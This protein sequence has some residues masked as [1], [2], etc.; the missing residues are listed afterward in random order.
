MIIQVHASTLLLH[1]LWTNQDFCLI[2]A[3]VLMNALAGWGVIKCWYKRLLHSYEF[4][5]MASLGRL[6]DN[7][8]QKWQK[9]TY[10]FW[11][12]Y[13]IVSHYLW[14][15]SIGFS[16]RTSTKILNQHQIWQ[17]NTSP[18]S[19]CRTD[20]WLAFWA[21]FQLN[22][23]MSLITIIIIIIIVINYCSDI[24][25]SI[26]S[27]RNILST[28]RGGIQKETAIREPAIIFIATFIIIF[29]WKQRCDRQI[30]RQIDPT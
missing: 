21:V 27:L 6:P 4:K 5:S 29:C 12:E 3:P 9:P 24:I 11:I 10:C 17:Q 23:S 7:G 13:S 26:T 28:L 1:S 19:I 20:T 14:Y 8:R 22:S 15:N 16:G 25:F 30:L 2:F 18:I